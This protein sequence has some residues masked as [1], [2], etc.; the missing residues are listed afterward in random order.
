MKRTEFAQ[1]VCCVDS[2]NR[3][4]E[5]RYQGSDRKSFDAHG[6]RLVNRAADVEAFALEWRNENSFSGAA[7]EAS[8]TAYVRE[9]IDC[10]CANRVS[11]CH[12]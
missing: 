6:H 7:G 5:K 11:E 2:E 8:K 4:D 10:G 9:A 3:A 12:Q 1:F